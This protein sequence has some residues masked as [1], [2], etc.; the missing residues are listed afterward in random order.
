M[1]LFGK[2]QLSHEMARADDEWGFETNDGTSINPVGFSGS[3]LQYSQCP[4]PH[5]KTNLNWA[6]PHAYIDF[7]K[8][9][10][11]PYGSM[12]F[13]TTKPVQKNFQLMMMYSENQTMANQFFKERD[14]T[15]CDVYTKKYPTT[16][17]QGAGIA[18]LLLR[19]QDEYKT[20]AEKKA[21]NHRILGLKVG[22]KNIPGVGAAPPK[23][24]MKTLKRQTSASQSMKKALAKK[25]RVIKA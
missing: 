8:R 18:D 15:R 6:R 20:A 23:S 10:E 1:G 4:G 17:R 14:L 16:L 19:P 9:E 13:I 7:D 3:Q 2:I 5:E 24:A 25:N 22:E 12:M 11:E 21:G